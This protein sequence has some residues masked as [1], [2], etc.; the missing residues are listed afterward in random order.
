MSL[1]NIIAR[2]EKFARAIVHQN[3]KND[4]EPLDSKWQ[5]DVFYGIALPTAFLPKKGITR[6]EYP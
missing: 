4:L 3:Q 2:L 1:E 5:L 6:H